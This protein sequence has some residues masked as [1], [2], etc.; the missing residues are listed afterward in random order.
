MFTETVL[1]KVVFFVV[2]DDDDDDVL[3][4]FLRWLFL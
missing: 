3:F 1:S 4:V 2:D